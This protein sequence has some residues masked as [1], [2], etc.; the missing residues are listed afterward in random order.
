MGNRC[1]RTA[2]MLVAIGCLQAGCG[3]DDPASPQPEPIRPLVSAAIDEA[4]GELVHEEVTLTIPAGALGESAEL[5]VYSESA[6]HP[7][8]ETGIPVYRITG[9][10]TEFGTPV[11]L[12]IR[13]DLAPTDDDSLCFFLG[14]EREAYSGGGGLSWRAAAGRDSAGWFVAE[15]DRGALDLGEK[16]DDGTVRAAVAKDLKWLDSDENHFELCYNPAEVDRQEAAQALVSF[17]NVYHLFI[18]WGFDF[19]DDDAIWPLNIYIRKP[20]KSI[21]CYVA[22]PHGKGYFEFHPDLL[23][24][25]VNLLPVIAHEVFHSVQTFYDPRDPRTWGKLNQERMWLDEAAAG[26]LEAASHEDDRM[27][28]LGMDDDNCAALLAGLAGHPTLPGDAYGYGMAA[29][30]RFLVEDPASGQGEE[31]I[32]ELFEH[33]K[34]GGDVTDAIDAVVDPA[35]SAWCVAM[36]RKWVD[37]LIYEQY[38]DLV[39][40]YAWPIAGWLDS[41]VGARAFETLAVPDLGAGICKLFLEGDAPTN[42]TSLMV[43][44]GSADAAQQRE[45]LPITV[46]GRAPDSMPTLLAVGLDSL[47]VPDW[48]LV[49]QTYKDILVMVSRPYSTAPGHTGQRDIRVEAE[50]QIDLSAIDITRFT[51]VTIEVSTDN[52]YNG[53]VVIHNNIIMVEAALTWDGNGFFAN[54]ANRTFSIALNPATLALGNWS[55]SATGYT[56]G[57][58][59][60]VRR[61]AG[62]GVPLTRWTE[63][64]LIYVLRGVETCTLLTEVYSSL[65]RDINTDP[66]NYLVSYT[67]HDGGVSYDQSKIYLHFYYME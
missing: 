32:L 58:N 29:F 52:Q 10:P 61:L 14:E 20:V 66:F 39:F 56:I 19:G 7:F 26:W 23:Q 57:G 45:A 15:L 37:G 6:G 4:G 16:A 65:A 55:G 9:L 31:R 63:N 11:T 42:L 53:G 36:Q 59:Y 17:D 54:T 24:P 2:L 40:W 44:A 8:G 46:Y 5:A 51:D 3:S 64:E 33:F 25:G 12:R 34:S 28:P 1:C 21:A 41:A 47:N 49:R 13:H 67:C 62:P 43:K 48:P 50:V 30:I 38:P 27:S 22:A 60:Y 35:V 18:D